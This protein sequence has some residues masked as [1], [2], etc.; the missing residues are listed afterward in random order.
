MDD[1]R[2]S[3]RREDDRREHL[4]SLLREFRTAMLV[5]HAEDGDLRSRPLEVAEVREDATLVFATGLDTPKV[6]ELEDDA[7]VNVVLQDG[8]RFLSLSGRARLVRERGMIE[9]LWS[10]PW[11]VWFPGGKDD[12]S[13][14]LLEVRPSAAEYWDRSG[15]KGLKYAF[16]AARAVARGERPR[17]D[18]ERQ[19]A[20]VHLHEERRP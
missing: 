11:R 14:V 8:K 10:E 18:D 17:V 9:R 4:L 3:A 6:A 16:Q 13:L 1:E 7:R 19:N 5:T 15:F 20:K 2:T 12:P